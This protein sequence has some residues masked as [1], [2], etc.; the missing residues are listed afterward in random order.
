MTVL[1]VD[2]DRDRDPTYL[3]DH[4]AEIEAYGPQLVLIKCIDR[5]DN[6]LGLAPFEGEFIRGDLSTFGVLN[7]VIAGP[8]E[9][10]GDW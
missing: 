6:V 8:S 4:Y 2:R 5:L 1:T 7:T 9:P 3:A 10:S